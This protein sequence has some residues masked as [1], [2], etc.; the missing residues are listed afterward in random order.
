MIKL[1][2]LF[3]TVDALGPELLS[4]AHTPFID[5]LMKNGMRVLDARSGFP[6]LTTP[7]MSSILTGCWPSRHGVPSNCTYDRSSRRVVGR[8]RDL[9]VKT[10]AEVLSNENYSILSVQHFMLEGRGK[11]TYRQTNGASSRAITLEILNAFQS[12]KYDAVFCIYQA[13]DGTGHRY[14][15]LHPKTVKA[16]EA[17]DNELERL[18]VY[19]RN[20]WGQFIIVL[21]S[22][23]SMSRAEK[24]THLSLVRLLKSLSLKGGFLKE[25]EEAPIDWDYVLL[26]F[27]TLP[28]FLLSDKAKAMEEGICHLLSCQED[29]EHVFRKVE[30]AAIGN[31]VYADIAI[32]L[33]KGYTFAPALFI[34]FKKFGYHGTIHESQAIVV[35][36]GAGVPNL[37]IPT[38]EL[39]DVTPTTLR[40]LGIE[41]SEEFDGKI[42]KELDS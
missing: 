12:Y 16:L 24:S 25:G 42:P 19:L 14:G 11:V 7:M 10:I 38:A 40:L 26:R 13:V 27:P 2:L 5:D 3:V 37:E 36:A 41:T 32:S 33:L 20:I 22:D 17:I 34:L 39:V 23:H 29:V 31:S 30:L 21:C 1:P 8:L 4:V 28:I 6:T 9:K 35:Y 15:P 18:W